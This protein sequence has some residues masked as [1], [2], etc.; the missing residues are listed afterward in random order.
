M[1]VSLPTRLFGPKRDE[2]IVGWRK[3][4]NEAL[5]ILHTSPTFYYSDQIKED[6][7]GIKHVWEGREILLAQDRDK[8]RTL[9]NT[10]VILRVP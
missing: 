9:V 1:S 7:W 4:H 10:V 5:H 6:G 3:L 2:I 8:W